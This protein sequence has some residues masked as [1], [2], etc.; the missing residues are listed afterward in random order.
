MWK[1]AAAAQ[2]ETE[3]RNW[4]T[5]QVEFWP[6][7]G[8]NTAFATA[9]IAASCLLS[10]MATT[11][12]SQPHFELTPRHL[13]A[14]S[15]QMTD[16]ADHFGAT[17]LL[18]VRAASSHWSAVAAMTAED[19]VHELMAQICERGTTAV[20]HLWPTLPSH[21][22]IESRLRQLIPDKVHVLRRMLRDGAWPGEGAKVMA[23][24][25]LAPLSSHQTHSGFVDSSIS[26]H[27]PAQEE[28]EGC[29]RT[30]P[31]PQLS[32]APQSSV[33]RHGDTSPTAPLSRHVDLSC[34]S[35]L[36][37]HADISPATPLSR[38]E[39]AASHPHSPCHCMLHAMHSPTI[40]S[41]APARK[42]PSPGADLAPVRVLRKQVSMESALD[43][44]AS[45]QSFVSESTSHSMGSSRTV[46]SLTSSDIEAKIAVL[47]KWGQPLPPSPELLLPESSSSR[48]AK[49]PASW[50]RPK[51]HAVPESGRLRVSISH[52]DSLR[53]V[54]ATPVEGTSD[55]RSGSVAAVLPAVSQADLEQQAGKRSETQPQSVPK[56]PRA[57]R[58]GQSQSHT[59]PPQ[60][61]LDYQAQTP[62]LQPA[63]RD[64]PTP[65]H[66]A[67][68]PHHP[69]SQQGSQECQG[70]HQAASNPQAQSP[71]QMWPHVRKYTVPQPLKAAP[72]APTGGSM[73]Y[74]LQPLCKERHL[75][76]QSS[77][78]SSRRA[79]PARP[80]L[81]VLRPPSASQ[82][83]P[84]SPADS[85]HP[86]DGSIQP[87]APLPSQTH[88]RANSQPACQ[89]QSVGSIQPQMPL[90]SQAHRRAYSQP[91]SQSQSVV[92][93]QPE[94]QIKAGNVPDDHAPDWVEQGRGVITNDAVGN[95]VW[96]TP[97]LP[98]KWSGQ[99]KLGHL[100]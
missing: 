53:L 75:Q 19:V 90:P 22:L 25:S 17:N 26:R 100:F 20:D 87:Q 69:S 51:K 13:Q 50:L 52:I 14:F 35:P 86:V 3:W 92:T 59:S 36:S 10:S 62:Q 58:S 88:R 37:R 99:G 73:P 70:R 29:T 79:H 33:S 54:Q 9:Q 45:G 85:Q 44:S 93:A 84:N 4:A 32:R 31:S 60:A 27:G 8:I 24:L 42:A 97:Q 83:D 96:R 34:A 56:S 63:T 43:Q 5:L 16:V 11:G 7:K 39:H 82:M 2:G 41:A 95:H 98:S 81:S 40:S 30:V 72:P 57:V 68:E 91:A 67:L 1:H 47:T 78:K 23:P 18:P 94:T 74:P 80:A 15:R 55:L 21:M 76:H 6:G 71:L 48:H 64:S 65:T 46:H 38:H 66:R 89:Q 12:A 28:E 61:L 77:D 49:G